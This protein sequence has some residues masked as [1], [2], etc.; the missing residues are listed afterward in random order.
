MFGIGVGIEITCNKEIP[1]TVLMMENL[2]PNRYE[3]KNRNRERNRLSNDRS[4]G[5][6]RGIEIEVKKE[7]LRGNISRFDSGANQATIANSLGVKM[8]QVENLNCT[9]A[10]GS[11]NLKYTLIFCIGTS[12]TSHFSKNAPG[13]FMDFAD[14]Y[15]RKSYKNELLRSNYGTNYHSDRAMRYIGENNVRCEVSITKEVFSEDGYEFFPSEYVNKT[16]LDTRLDPFMA[17]PNEIIKPEIC[18]HN[19]NQFG[20]QTLYEDLYVLKKSTRGRKECWEHT[21]Q[22]I[23]VGCKC[24]IRFKYN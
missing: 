10:T 24:N 20:C 16:C 2:N 1:I 11:S 4:T 22:I 5:K 18:L 17:Q 15:T 6:L 14:D 12:A 19:D 13:P 3:D 7:P 9:I 21:S 8:K 23:A